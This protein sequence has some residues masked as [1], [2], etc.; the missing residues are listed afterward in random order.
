MCYNVFVSER[1]GAEISI[2]Q[3]EDVKMKTIADIN[4]K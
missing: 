3:K 1:S 2:N 4:I